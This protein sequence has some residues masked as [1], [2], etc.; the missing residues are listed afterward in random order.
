[1]KNEENLKKLAKNYLVARKNFREAADKI[2]ELNGNDNII[3]RIGEFIALQFL[4][5]KLKRK[6]VA[7]NENMVQVGYDIIAD[8]KKV[9]VKIITSENK[10]GSTTPI[11]NPWDEL[12]IIELGENSKI[13]K[14]GFITKNRFKKAINNNFL[15]NKNPIASRSMLKK[16]R[17]FDI[18]GN[19]YSSKDVGEYI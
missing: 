4:K 11:K 19:I 10:K 16:D 5:H 15:K 2:P 7:R 6:K 1:M 14:I 13:N 3:G 9:S 12:I 18:Y 17:L 8:N